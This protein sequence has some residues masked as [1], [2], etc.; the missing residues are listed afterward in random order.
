MKFKLA[1]GKKVNP[2]FVSRLLEIAKG[3][4]WGI[5]QVNHLMAC[6]AFESAE[7]FSPSIKNA[8]GSGAVGLIQFMPST[9]QGL[10]T[11]TAQLASMSSTE[12]LAF[13][14]S[15]FKPYAKRV[16]TLED[17]YMAILMPKFIGCP[18]HTVVFDATN[19]PIAYKQN[20]GLDANKDM[21]VTV[22]ECAGK[23]RE[24]LLRGLSD[25]FSSEENW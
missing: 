22:G 15:Y 17:F 2:L 4:G 18:P 3:F 14:A 7:T 6:M 12:Q 1:F 13:V 9:A 10:G 16:R 21:K 24:K 23:V 11:S 25:T 5:D 19:A 20:A 8:A